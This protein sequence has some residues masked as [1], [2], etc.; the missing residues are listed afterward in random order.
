MNY[1]TSISNYRFGVLK[2]G[3][4]GVIDIFGGR[5]DGV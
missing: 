5:A 1:F 4:S 3:G 2:M